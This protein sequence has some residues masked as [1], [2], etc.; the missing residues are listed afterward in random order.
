MV[1]VY[2]IECLME[3]RDFFKGRKL[4]ILLVLTVIAVLLCFVEDG[5]ELNIIMIF[6][7]IWTVLSTSMNIN[8]LH[9]I[10]PGEMKDRIFRILMKGF[11]V[12][13]FN[14]LWNSAILIIAAMINGYSLDESLSY[15]LSIE[16][17]FLI[18]YI[19]VDL[20]NGYNIK[21]SDNEWVIRH[22]ALY[23]I[24][25]ASFFI[26]I[27]FINFL[28]E[29][30]EGAWYMLFVI[31]SYLSAILVLMCMICILRYSNTEY[32]NIRKT[33]KLFN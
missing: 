31:L 21:Q 16:I 5:F 14:I 17:P 1:R 7:A 25:I 13:L 33:E 30:L 22:K 4:V 32:E 18:A 23:Y 15:M 11:S 29:F 28:S 10:L 2:I 27:I 3:W 19:S 26:M 6:F 8:K 9:Y 12:F 24:T 20:N